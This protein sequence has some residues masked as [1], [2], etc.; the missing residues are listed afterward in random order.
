MQTLAQDLPRIP[1]ARGAHA[2]PEDGMCV[3]ECVAYVM[4]EGH[5][6]TPKCACPV[7]AT[8]AMYV[9]DNY[10]KVHEDALRQRVFLLA[11][12]RQSEDVTVARAYYLFDCLLRTV[13][14]AALRNTTLI[15]PPLKQADAFASLRQV[16]S[17]AQFPAVRSAAAKLKR[18]GHKIPA[19]LAERISYIAEL[20]EKNT[21]P[22]MRVVA[23]IH[24]FKLLA[25]KL[26]VPETYGFKPVRIDVIGVL[27]ALLAIGDTED[28][29]V[30]AEMA[31]R[32]A[33]L[34]NRPPRQPSSPRSW[35]ATNN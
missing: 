9:N 22:K 5:T 24:V 14:P 29:P 7:A 21:P 11:G 26:D 28:V 16:E 32:I 13:I 23:I 8:F 31:K 15:K 3:M 1:L 4:G 2:T 19:L 33:T 27:D 34:A 10:F 30:S 18:Y 6:Y 12:S 17:P 35:P 25:T 20:F